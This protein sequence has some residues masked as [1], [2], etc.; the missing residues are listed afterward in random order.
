MR[1]LSG[2][3]VLAFASAPLT[4]A[5]II[6]FVITVRRAQAV[7]ETVGG[8]TADEMSVCPVQAF[9]S[10]IFQRWRLQHALVYI[11][12]FLLPVGDVLLLSLH[13]REP[14]SSPE[15]LREECLRNY[16]VDEAV[17]GALGKFQYSF[18]IRGFGFL[19]SI[20]VRLR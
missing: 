2:A 7:V 6:K 3:I 20:L 1:T 18:Q 12:E 17:L 10:L 4:D 14:E 15:V 19:Q 5:V 8:V 16:P 9:P 11:R 13:S